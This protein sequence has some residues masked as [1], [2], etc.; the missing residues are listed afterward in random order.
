MKRTQG[1]IVLNVLFGTIIVGCILATI[2]STSVREA[3][4]AQLVAT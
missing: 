2:V 1:N 4:T 3:R